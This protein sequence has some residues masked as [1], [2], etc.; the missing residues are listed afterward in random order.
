ML[1]NMSIFQ[2]A[3]HI[4]YIQPALRAHA[5]FE[6]LSFFNVP[7]NRVVNGRGDATRVVWGKAEGVVLLEVLIGSN[8]ETEQKRFT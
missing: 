7:L 5:V 4:I 8:T 6:C 3:L 1:A 2:K